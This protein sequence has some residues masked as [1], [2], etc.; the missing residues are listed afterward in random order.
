MDAI[1]LEGVSKRFKKVKLRSGC[2]KIPLLPPGMFPIKW[3]GRIAAALWWPERWQD[4]VAGLHSDM[5]LEVW[6]GNGA[7]IGRSDDRTAS[8]ERTSG[9]MARPVG[10]YLRIRAFSLP[11]GAQTVYWAAVVSPLPTRVL[12][13]RIRRH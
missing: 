4:G 10:A 12:P 6:D 9:T 13:P 5:D 2:V 8:F 7:L 1:L 3:N 11:H